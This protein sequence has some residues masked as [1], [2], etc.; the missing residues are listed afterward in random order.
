VSARIPAQPHFFLAG[1]GVV[2]RLN[3]GFYSKCPGFSP[4]DSAPIQTSRGC[5]QRGVILLIGL[6]KAAVS[7]SGAP[8]GAVAA[9]P[10][11]DLFLVPATLT[12]K[13][14]LLVVQIRGRSLK[15]FLI[16]RWSVSF[17]DLPLAIRGIG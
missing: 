16:F 12:E 1:I 2:L 3:R 10:Y 5:S 9:F 15:R 4:G 14:V 17:A 6:E 7:R 13:S 8:G 11:A